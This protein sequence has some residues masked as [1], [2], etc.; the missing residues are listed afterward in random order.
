MVLVLAIFLR[1]FLTDQLAEPDELLQTLSLRTS[2]VGS[3]RPKEPSPADHPGPIFLKSV[4]NKNYK[5]RWI[6][7]AV[8][9]FTCMTIIVVISVIYSN[10]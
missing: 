3:R 10:P 8:T 1:L 6:V 4:V 7:V 2:S 5:S 9:V